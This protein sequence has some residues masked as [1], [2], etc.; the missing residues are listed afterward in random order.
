[1]L[2]LRDAYHG[3]HYGAQTATGIGQARQLVPP[4]PGLRAG[5]GAAPVP[6]ALRPGGG[7]VPRRARRAL[8]TNTTGAVAGLIA[9]PIQGYGG[10]VE[11]PTG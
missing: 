11:M 9:E 3:M 4:A 1:M 2:T 8:H 6:R 10:I 5:D 7:A